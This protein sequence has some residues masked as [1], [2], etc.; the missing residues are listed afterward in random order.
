MIFE[1]A[2]ETQYIVAHWFMR[3]RFES[4]S[5]QR[6]ATNAAYLLTYLLTSYFPF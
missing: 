6:R 5:T 3:L 4:T 1:A 2:S